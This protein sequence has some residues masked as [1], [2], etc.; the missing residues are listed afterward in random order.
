MKGITKAL[1]E[2][3]LHT[4]EALRFVGLSRSTYY[5][6]HRAYRRVPKDD[7][8]LIERIKEV[9]GQHPMWGYRKIWAYLKREGIVVNRKRVLRICRK[10]GL[11]VSVK[12]YKAV[13]SIKPK[14]K[15]EKP[16][17]IIGIDMTSIQTKQGKVYYIAVIDWHTREILGSCV[18]M[19]ARTQEWLEALNEALNEGWPEGAKSQGIKIVSDNGSQPTSRRFG[20][21]CKSLEI[22]QIFTTYNK[23]KGNANTERYFRTVKEEYGQGNMGHLNN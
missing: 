3:G 5:Y 1:V 20:E 22:E 16:R 9:K 6:K 2:R 18:S 11:T 12:R 8:K 7:S 10:N 4:T 21:F 23:P 17:E 19:R 15:P 14:I 13:R